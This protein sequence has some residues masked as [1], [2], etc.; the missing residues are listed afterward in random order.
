VN[1]SLCLLLVFFSV[2]RSTA[3][4]GKP[5]VIGTTD[6][7]YSKI[8]GENR[9]L[10]VHLPTTEPDAFSPNLKYPVVYVLDGESSLFHAT[11][12]ITEALSGGSGNFAY[13]KMIVVGVT[14]TDRT[15]DLTP[16]HATDSSVMPGFLLT[17]SGGGENFLSFFK[18]ELIP[19]IES[20][21]PAAPYRVL[22]GH[23]FGGLLAIHALGKHPNLFQS[24]IAIDPSLW[25]DTP[26]FLQETK[27]RLSAQSAPEN[28]LYV[29]IAN[30]MNNQFDLQRV[31]TDTTAGT[32]PI[33]SILDFDR[34]MQRHKPRA[35]RSKYYPD[36]D[37]GSVPFVAVY[38][39]LPFV[40]NFYGLNFPFGEFF[41][42]EFKYDTLL[43]N[44]YKKVSQR[45]GYPVLPPGELV[46]AVAHQ[47]MDMKQWERSYKFFQLN[48][49]NYP[50]SYASYEAI[51]E[52]YEAK[53]DKNKAKEFYQKAAYLNNSPALRE[54]LAKFN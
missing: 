7:L 14:N 11:V 18:N 44:H 24:H 20:T 27:Q 12:A 6:T 45:M 47:L 19:H 43:A 17:N 4:N 3:Q 39:A 38:D 32:Q 25:W 46:N 53:G 8:L 28:P 52:Y 40:F 33:R 41:K 30:T 26:R 9:T 1:K 31:A 42:P 15:R 21:F 16:T 35:Y 37:H 54:K 10:L 23:S 36:Y 5:I 50:K 29:A 34:F 13:P 2:L 48:L 49:L 51:G 22:I